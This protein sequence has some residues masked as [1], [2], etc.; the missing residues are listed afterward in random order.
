MMPSWA[1][2]GASTN[3]LDI[4]ALTQATIEITPIGDPLKNGLVPVTLAI[5]FSNGKPVDNLNISNP[6]HIA[7]L[8][9][10]YG[11]EAV[12]WANI[13]SESI[14]DDKWYIEP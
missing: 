7:L 6:D 8:E 2:T 5:P 13:L 11:T 14:E 12:E 1:I 10:C 3:V 4:P 9:A